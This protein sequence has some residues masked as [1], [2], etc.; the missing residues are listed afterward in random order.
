MNL[1]SYQGALVCQGWGLASTDGAFVQNLSLACDGKH[2]RVRNL[3]ASSLCQSGYTRE[4]AKRI[5]RYVERQETWAQM[6]QDFRHPREECLAAL[7]T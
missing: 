3:A 6:A 4:F 7:G 2:S 1:R 5:V